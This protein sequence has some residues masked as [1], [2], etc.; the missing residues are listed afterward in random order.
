MI[1]NIGN[2][3]LSFYVKMLEKR[4]GVC[5]VKD[6]KEDSHI[7]LWDFDN[8]RLPVITKILFDLQLK[9]N[10]P[11]IYILASSANS[12]H[13]YCFTARL[14]REIIHILSDT[15]CI[16]MMYL[17]L[18]MVRGYYTLRISK[19]KADDFKLIKV[20]PSTY[21]DEMSPDRVSINEYL[22]TNKGSVKDEIL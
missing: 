2:I 21:C 15:S 20:L 10:L 16:D 1:V 9:Y 4:V 7:L 6:T 8:E 18:G 13:A 14:F 11:S 5:S 19:R 3:R 12:Y 22:T 17:R